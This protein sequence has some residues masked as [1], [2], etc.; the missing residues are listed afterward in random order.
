MN[1]SEAKE[2]LWTDFAEFT[3][4]QIESIIILLDA[5]AMLIIDKPNLLDTKP[6]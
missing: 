5:F 1:V 3:D 2:T 4:T 6:P